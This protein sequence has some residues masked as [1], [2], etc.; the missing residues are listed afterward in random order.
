[1]PRN[2][3]EQNRSLFPAKVA[4]ALTSLIIMIGL[5]MVTITRGPNDLYTVIVG[6]VALAMAVAI[7]LV[8]LRRHRRRP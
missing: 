4:A 7:T 2:Q 5:F 8:L 6:A 1:M 3:S